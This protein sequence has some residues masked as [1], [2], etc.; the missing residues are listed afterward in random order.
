MNRGCQTFSNWIDG[1]ESG[2]A[3]ALPALQALTVLIRHGG[4]SFLEI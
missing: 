2:E 4:S 3:M 1:S